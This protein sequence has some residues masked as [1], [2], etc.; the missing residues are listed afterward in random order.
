[1]NAP[2][3]ILMTVHFYAE[4]YEDDNRHVVNQTLNKGTFG[5]KQRR[6]NSAFTFLPKI[7]IVFIAKEWGNV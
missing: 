4:E 7:D 1:M 2:I 6:H 5:R 3:V